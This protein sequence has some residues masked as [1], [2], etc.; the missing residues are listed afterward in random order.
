MRLCGFKRVNVAKGESTPV[1]VEV[2]VK[3][4]R[5]WD[6]GKKGYVVDAGKYEVMV[7]GASDEV[8]GKVAVVVK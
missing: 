1:T 2:P 5:R 8:R 3:E 6:E 7:G 4:W